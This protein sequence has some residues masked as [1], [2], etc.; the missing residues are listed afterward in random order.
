MCIAACKLDLSIS[1]IT[2]STHR[3]EGLENVE[4]EPLSCS[5]MGQELQRLYWKIE[6]KQLKELVSAAPSQSYCRMIT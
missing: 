4:V 2:T 5:E 1:L 3:I 6:E